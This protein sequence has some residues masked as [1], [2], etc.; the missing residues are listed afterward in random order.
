MRK[1]TLPHTKPQIPAGLP[2]HTL[3]V[4]VPMYNEAEN[5]APLLERIHFALGP[6][7]WP[8]ELILVDDG[9]NDA[10]PAELL[11]CIRLHGSHVR[12]LRLT[13]N[14][15]QTAA[16]QAGVDTARGNVIATLDADLQNDPIDIPRM[17]ARLFKE[18][19]DLVAGWR[20]SRRDALLRRI[21]A[22][23]ANNLIARM[24]PIKLRDYGCGLKVFRASTLKNTRLHGEMHRSIPVWLTTATTPRR[25]AQEAVTHHPRASGRSRYGILHTCRVVLDLI[26]IHL[27]MRSRPGQ[28]FGSIGIGL[29]T[30]G[31]L[32]LLYLAV[33]GFFPGGHSGIRPLLFVG[34]FLVIGGLQLVTSGVQAELLARIHHESGNV[35]T[36]RAQTTSAPADDECWHTEPVVMQ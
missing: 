21:P 12:V 15:G 13:R 24:T 8:W 28:S 9:S 27:F 4:V 29:G 1:S 16:I 5:I 23:I 10:T 3:S 32:I 34:L 11:R 33:A 19:L 18:E 22:Q 25:T 2:K 7:P 30:L 36:Y 6:Y 17:V 35:S 20:K 14:Y 31:A 26:F